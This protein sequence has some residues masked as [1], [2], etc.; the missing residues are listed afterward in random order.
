MPWNL[1]QIKVGI[2]YL[3]PLL[4]V[5]QYIGYHLSQAIR[6]ELKNRKKEK[7]VAYI[8]TQVLV[9]KDDPAFKN[10]TKPI[11]NFLTKKQAEDKAKENGYLYVEDAKREG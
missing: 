6:N 8:L 1:Q 4:N 3:C 2:H 5:G 7:E 11:G 10:P 9:D